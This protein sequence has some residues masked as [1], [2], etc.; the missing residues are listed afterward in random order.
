MRVAE[1]I[2]SSMRISFEAE[3]FPAM[4]V[5]LGA[6]LADILDGPHSPVFFG[7]KSGNCGTCLVDVNADQPSL[8]SVPS[9]DERE[10]LE[11]HAADR[12]TARLACQLKAVC[13]LKLKYLN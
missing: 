8:L 10:F 12:P 2:S 6:P 7:C 13:N 11:A 3:G 9:S 4:D 5:P 1:I